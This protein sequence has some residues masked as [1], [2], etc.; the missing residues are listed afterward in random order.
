MSEVH[1]TNMLVVLAVDVDVHAQAHAHVDF[2]LVLV[3][4][5]VSSFLFVCFLSAGSHARGGG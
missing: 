3:V 2:V 1:N 4:A 5:V